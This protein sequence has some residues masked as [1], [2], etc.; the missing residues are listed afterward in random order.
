[1]VTFDKIWLGWMTSSHM[2]AGLVV[3]FVNRQQRIGR[4]VGSSYRTE[5]IQERPRYDMLFEALDHRPYFNI[6]VLKRSIPHWIVYYWNS[7]ASFLLFC[8]AVPCNF[9][10]M[11]NNVPVYRTIVVKDSLDRESIHCMMWPVRSPDLNPNDI[12]GMPWGGVLLFG[13]KFGE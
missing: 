8:A 2:R 5:V 10:L 9:L 1:M 11:D 12:F 4:E 6:C 3:F 7:A 13:H